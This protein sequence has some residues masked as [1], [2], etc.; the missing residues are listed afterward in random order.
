VRASPR[1][2]SVDLDIERED[3]Q[4]SDKHDHSENPH[5]RERRLHGDGANKV[6]GDKNLKADQKPASEDLAT[7]PV[8]DARRRAADKIASDG[9]QANKPYFVE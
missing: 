3:Q 7:S 5:I 9:E 8:G 4:G 2:D 1:Q 6:G